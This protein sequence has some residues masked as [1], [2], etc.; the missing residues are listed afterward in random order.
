[1]IDQKIFGSSTIRRGPGFTFKAMS[2]PNKMAVV[3]DPGIP[4]VSNGTKDPVQA[5]LLA[6]SGAAKPLIEPLPN[7][8][9]SSSDAR[10]RSTA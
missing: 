1:M 3:P 2:A 4:S 10:F 9:R 8:R 7:F 6:V 5:A